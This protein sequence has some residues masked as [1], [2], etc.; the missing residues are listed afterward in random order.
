MKAAVSPHSG[1]VNRMCPTAF[2][3]ET[4]PPSSPV[5]SIGIFSEYIVS[6]V[7]TVGVT[8]AS[9]LI[10]PVAGHAT[11]SI[12]LLLVVVAGLR[13]SRGPV[14]CIAAGST[15]AWYTIFIPPRFSFHIGTV[16]DLMIFASFFAVAM[17]MGHLTS[18]LRLK[19]MS[20][21]M[22]ERRTAALYDLVRQAG[23]A[24][25]LD[26]GLRAAVELTENLFGVRAALLIN[27][28]GRLTVQS[29]ATGSFTLDDREYAAACA[30]FNQTMPARQCDGRSGATTALHLPLRSGNSVKGVFS[31]L[32]SPGVSFDAA[33]R[34]LLEAFTMLIATV[35]EKD[36]LLQSSKQS[37][38]IAASERLQRA[39]LQ[40]VSHELK[41]P[42]A[43]VQAGF[44]ALVK[45]LGA[46]SRS[47]VT[48]IEVQR[49]ISRLHRVINNLLDMTRIESNVVHPKLDW[50]DVG[51]MIEAAADLAKDGIGEH[52]IMIAI[53]PQ[54][55]MVRL[56]QALIEQCVCNLL[57]NA[58]AHSPS[59]SKIDVAAQVA[60]G[61]LMLSVRDQGRGIAE[62]DSPRIFDVFYRGADSKPG[63]TGLGLAIVDGFVR[64][65][66]GRVTVANRKP[67]GAEFTI[68]L[69]VETLATDL[70][71]KFA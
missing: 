63:G 34:E 7:A 11:P 21:R 69:S 12:Y 8:A 48:A 16:D 18:Q 49:A 3:K 56:D 44:D 42:L 26:E 25:D 55:P 68:L 22:R 4:F 9:L 23:L 61:A 43:A 15:I 31:I 30:A 52:P 20:E 67:C 60:A 51:E 41:T 36:E 47:G 50:C 28:E 46:G 1:P 71:E 17:A 14:L 58:A 19:E 62:I 53:D 39:L 64:A 66:G 10:E 2:R 29:R 54:L 6:V 57:L 45:E 70:I 13:L 40:S 38:I 24:L 37:E 5:R 59:G 35:L 65:H 27:Q 33:Q 32:P